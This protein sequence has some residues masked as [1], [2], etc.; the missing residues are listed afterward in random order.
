MLSYGV[1]K[2]NRCAH[3]AKQRNEQEPDHPPVDSASFWV[4][5]KF[6]QHQASA[7]RQ[8]LGERGDREGPNVDRQTLTHDRP[9]RVRAALHNTAPPNVGLFK[10]AHFY[11]FG[12]SS[13]VYEG[14]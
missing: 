3:E 12:K 6:P 9:Y 5:K 8:N 10:I 7:R 11:I 1:H 13:A 2:E 14:L 4:H